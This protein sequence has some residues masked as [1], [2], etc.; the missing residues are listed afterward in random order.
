MKYKQLL[1]MLLVLIGMGHAVEVRADDFT[2]NK[3]HFKCM[4]V[5]LDRVRFTLPTGNTYR[6]NDGVENGYVYVSV[7]GGPEE[8]VFEW[9]CDNYSQVDNGCKIKAYKDGRYAL[10]EKVQGGSMTAGCRIN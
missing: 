6:T 5:G 2:Y 7:N 10:I 9:K 8:C 3:S 1:L 4:I